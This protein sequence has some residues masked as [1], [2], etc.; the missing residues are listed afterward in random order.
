MP[1]APPPPRTDAVVMRRARCL[2]RPPTKSPAIRHLAALI[3]ALIASTAPAAEPASSAA[4]GAEPGT[5]AVPG[6]PMVE[7]I[8]A[9]GPIPLRR[10]ISR[11]EGRISDLRKDRDAELAALDAAAAEAQ[12]AVEQARAAAR[13]T[14]SAPAMDSTPAAATAADA[15]DT[16]H[17]VDANARAEQRQ[18]VIRRYRRLLAKAHA[19]L[20]RLLDRQALIDPLAPDQQRLRNAGS[21]DTAAHWPAPGS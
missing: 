7:D 11:A 13:T 2:R 15:L 14:G 9:L 16:A 18:E 19:R 17:L 3:A 6:I 8:D 1:T 21:P 20:E 5:A 12:S 4:A 10:E